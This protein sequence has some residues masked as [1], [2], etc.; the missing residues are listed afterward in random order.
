M[1][2]PQVTIGVFGHE[3]E[4]I[5]K[6]ISPQGIKNILYHKCF[7]HDVIQAVLQQEL[8]L[9]IGKFITTTPKLF[10]GILK[11]RIGYA[12][13]QCDCSIQSTRFATR[14][15]TISSMMAFHDY[16]DIVKLWLISLPSLKSIVDDIV[17]KSCGIAVTVALVVCL[18]YM[19]C[20]TCFCCMPV[21]CDMFL[22]AADMLPVIFCS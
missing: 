1:P 5:E 17:V 7:P 11:I 15:T 18:C 10:D 20:V 12:H 22:A 9:N 19:S 21:T 3:E 16:N 6:P 4:V 2:P 13:E 14:F 8:L